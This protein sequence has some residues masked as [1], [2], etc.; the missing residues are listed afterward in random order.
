MQTIADDFDWEMYD[1]LPERSKV[2]Q[3][4]TL[5]EK[6]I[7]AMYGD[8]Q[9]RG[10]FLP[11][12]KA[13][14][15]WRLRRGEVT[16]Y[17]GI[18]G[19]G[20]SLVTSYIAQSLMR[21]GERVLIASFEMKPESTMERM[22][23]QAGATDEP[24]IPYIR[25][26]HAWTDNR[27]WIYDHFGTCDPRKAIAVCNYAARELGVTHVFVDSLMKCVRGQDDYT[28]QKVFVG[29]LCSLA[30]GVDIHVH[31]VAHARKA[32]HESDAI[33][34]FSVRGAGEIADQVDNVALVQRN[35]SKE[36]DVLNGEEVDESRPD[37]FFNLCKQRHQRKGS[38]FEGI[39]GLYFDKRTETYSDA[40]GLRA[41]PLNLDLSASRVGA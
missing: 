1:E 40:P 27:L 21:Q 4:S 17:A 20:K 18:N 31:L 3:A 23:R 13:A 30:M 34:K 22:V 8:E 38:R 2:I 24:S 37:V 9:A 41:R 26:F 7:A 32:Q 28:G 39:M 33:D 14:D 35:L 25:A 11:W 12:E 29:D 5:A 19:H 16:L 15:R 36:R 6:V 10:A